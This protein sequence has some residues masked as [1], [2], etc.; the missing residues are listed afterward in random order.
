[1]LKRGKQETK[2]IREGFNI[3]CTS[4]VWTQMR[5]KEK[6]QQTLF[7]KKNKKLIF[8]KEKDLS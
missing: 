6:K 3:Q 2:V 7:P 5:S 8:L 4:H 1:M